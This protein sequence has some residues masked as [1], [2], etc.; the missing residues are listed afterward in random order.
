MITTAP[1]TNQAGWATLEHW[2]RERAMNPI[3]SLMWRAEQHPQRSSAGIIL[4]L[5]DRV[6]DWR[7]FRRA[8]DWGTALVPRLRQRVVEPALPVGPPIWAADPHFDLDYHVRRI[9]L[10]AP[11]AMRQLLD[12]AEAIART[13]LDRTRPLWVG[14]LV[15]GLADGRAAYLLHMHHCL[16]DGAA[17]VAL[18]SSLHSDRREPSPGKPSRPAPPPERPSR[19]GLT[20]DALS[21]G[22]RSAPRRALDGL[23]A[24]W[25]AARAPGDTVEY[26]A[27]LR[28]VVASATELPLSPLGAR[29]TNRNWRF[30][31]LECGLD[32]LRL[33]ADAAGGSLNDAYV[34]ALLGGIGRYHDA[35]GLAPTDIPMAMPVS[36]RRPQDEPG[37]NRFT[38]A[39]LPGPASIRD[40]AERIAAIRGTVLSRRAEPA[41]DYIGAA[42][43]FLGHVPVPFLRALAGAVMPRLELSASNV[44]G[45]R[46]P[47]YAA[48]A[49]VERL[50]LLGP[51][52]N[53]AML[54]VLFSH[55]DTCCIG[56]SCDATVFEHTDL[57][58]RCL[59]EGFDEVVALGAS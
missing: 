45:I 17:L 54:A 47:V 22:A 2:G 31:I 57:L 18:L 38:A 29:Q 23:R 25:R 10:P 48:G 28:R 30:G 4:E 35:Q 15:D 13:P 40:P 50:F 37:G 51:L 5:F 21:G 44:P 49:R 3:E 9:S 11:G 1:A 32:E 43:P 24:G 46:H 12:L 7:R 16:T 41:L 36:I 20:L 52:P 19:W 59:H 33:A 27:S 42:A 39:F 56:I 58:W 34:A 55:G 6:P 26:L 14:T 53:V 8:H